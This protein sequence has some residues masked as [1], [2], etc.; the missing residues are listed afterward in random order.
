MKRVQKGQNGDLLSPS[1]EPVKHLSC[2]LQRKLL[3]RID[4]QSKHFRSSGKSYP[5]VI[6]QSP[7]LNT[8]DD[9][10]QGHPFL[11]LLSQLD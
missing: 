6:A 5:L 9:H 7:Y 8:R 2:G 4:K 10:I 3:K 11:Y 1:L